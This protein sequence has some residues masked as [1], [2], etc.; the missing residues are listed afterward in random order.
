MIGCGSENPCDTWR[1]DIAEH[2][3]GCAAST[4]ECPDALVNDTLI[5]DQQQ[6]DCVTACDLEADCAAIDGSDADA[7]IALEE[8]RSACVAAP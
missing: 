1:G 4:T 2:Y 7:A 6:A 8:C 3:E 5:E